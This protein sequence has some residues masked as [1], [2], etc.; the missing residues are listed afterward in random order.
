LLRALALALLLLCAPH[1]AAAHL[2]V[3]D[4]RGREVRLAR[5]AERIVCLIESA[6]SGL[7][8]LGAQDQL[9]GISRNVY[10]G[11][12]FARYAALDPRIRDRRLPAPGNWDFVSIEGVAALRPDLVV[13]WSQ[14]TDSIAVLEALGIPVYGVFIERREDV[15]R[16]LR[17]LGR[18]T[19]RGARAEELVAWTEGELA[20]LAGRLEGLPESGRPRVYFMWAQGDLETSCRGSTVDDLIRMAGGR[21][22]CEEEAEHRVVSRERLLAWDPDVVVMWVNDRK[23]PEDVLR[24]PQWRSVS[25]ARTGRVHELPEVFLCDLWTLKFVHPIKLLGAW[26]H[27]ERFAGVDLDREADRML[28]ALYGPGAGRP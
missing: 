21:N 10:E 16:E 9:V 15:Y 5:P 28:R 13:I 4:F 11:Q 8:M 17:D 18:L 23:D 1:P 3:T 12:V 27:P 20:A 24:D 14:Q 25:A 22:A 19:G 7:Y 6:L 2:A 26:L